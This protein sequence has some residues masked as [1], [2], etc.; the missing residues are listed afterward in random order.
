MRTSARLLDPAYPIRFTL[1]LILACL[2]LAVWL[3]GGLALVLVCLVP[4]TLVLALSPLLAP[5]ALAFRSR[6]H[7]SWFWRSYWCPWLWSWLCRTWL[8]WPWL[9]WGWLRCI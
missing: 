8:C 4:M 3:V 9:C 6:L 5:L 2:G 7:T 1:G